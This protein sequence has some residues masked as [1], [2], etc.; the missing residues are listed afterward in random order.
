M[1]FSDKSA[2]AN[3]FMTALEQADESAIRRCYADNAAI[4]HNFDGLEQTV[5]DNIASLHWL[6]GHLVD[7]RYADVVHS[8]IADGLLQRHVM[9]GKTASGES[10]A[11][12]ACVIFTIEDGRMTRLEEYL[13]PTPLLGLI[14]AG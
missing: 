4:W 11:M 1:N 2:L 7:I 9:T 5:E 14:A 3:Q 8:D 6:R 12:P 10:L 13:D